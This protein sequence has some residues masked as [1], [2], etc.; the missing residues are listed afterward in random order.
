MKGKDYCLFVTMIAIMSIIGL[1]SSDIYLP[2][3]PAMAEYFHVAPQDIQ[4]TLSVYLLGFSLS[5]IIYGSLSDRFGRRPIIII[6]IAIYIVFSGL[7]MVSTSIKALIICRFF[8][9]VGACSGMVLGRAI[10]GDLFKKE[11]AVQIF[12]SIFPIIGISPAISP[13]IG[14]L[15]TSY[16]N[17]QANFLFLVIVGIL[18]MI[19]IATSLKET[20]PQDKRI[21]ISITDLITHYKE[22]LCNPIYLAYSTIVCAAH[23]AY[24]A[25]LVNSP[26][27]FNKLGFNPDS[28]GF[29]YITISLSYISGNILNKKMIKIITVDSTLLLGTI[30]FT[31]GGSVMLILAWNTINS[32]LEL[33]IPMSI[34]TFG[35]GFLLPL[36]VASGI[37]IFPKMAG[38][39]SGLMGLMQLGAAS[40]S[41]VAAGHILKEL[42]LSASLVIFI[43]NIMSVFSILLI[44]IMKNRLKQKFSTENL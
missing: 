4:T 16:F 22:I 35:N 34:L 15:L 43:T 10:V 1:M 23:G 8:Q 36:G 12:A 39:A 14:G 33:I 3:L 28:I 19:I 11:E 26:F 32:P 27:I 38:T 41:S 40:I 18:L 37:S 6:G 9:A 30:I 7:C 31:T 17:W 2:A 42:T 44:L 25:Y 21:G 5:Q 24:F 13:I 29:F 20:L